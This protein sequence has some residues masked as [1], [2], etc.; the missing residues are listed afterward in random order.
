MA[1][2]A[3][4]DVAELHHRMRATPGAANRVVALLSKMMSLAEHW[5]LRPAGSNPCR[6]VQHYR[7]RR[8]ERFLAN[9]EIARLGDTL[10]EL[11]Q[12]RLE[13]TSVIGAIRLLIFTGARRSELLNLRWTDVD[14]EKAM[15][16]I[17]DSKT[18]PKTIPLSAP[19][20]QLLHELPRT[21]EWVFPTADGSGPVSLSKPWGRIR[22]RA[23]L[24][25]VRIH[26]LRHSFASV[27]A[28]AGLGLPIIGRL[29]GHRQPATTSRYAH[30]ADDPVR[31][32]SEA[33]GRRLAA[34]MAG[35][36][37][38]DLVSFSRPYRQ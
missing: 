29:L 36:G 24:E 21:V 18:G 14:F 19:A 5:G 10:R 4:A 2:I 33:I 3:F 37:E 7:E 35:G 17:R 26:D 11:E 32:A 34:A 9:E 23:S 16:W 25:D 13:P 38:G 31:Q 22:R 1:E 15:L 28:G 8:M 30:L 12:A 6:H 27:G 20:L